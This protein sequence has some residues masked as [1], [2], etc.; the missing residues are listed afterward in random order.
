MK[1]RGFTL[2]EVV[3]AMAL[4]IL[5]LAAFIGAFVMAKRSAIISENR[6]EAIHDAR[7]EMEQLLTCRYTDPQLNAGPHTTELATV[8]YGVAVVTNSQYTVKN[9]SVTSK[10]VNPAG[11]I[12]S[13]LVLSG[14]MSSE[15][16]Q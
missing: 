10:W 16:H 3:I 6:M 2:V 11:N 13:I 7:N 9:I 15:L 4:L 8:R 14:S 1:K 12:T 5:T